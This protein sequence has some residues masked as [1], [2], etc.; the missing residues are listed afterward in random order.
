M[1]IAEIAFH[2]SFGL[3]RPDWARF[4]E[5][6]EAQP[7]S[8]DRNAIWTEAASRWLLELGRALGNE[9]RLE[10]S[11]NYLLLSAMERRLAI[12]LLEIGEKTLES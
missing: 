6:V 8:A 11:G 9:Y 10:E 4:G 3:P 1:D 5:W 2:E 12:Q 7:P